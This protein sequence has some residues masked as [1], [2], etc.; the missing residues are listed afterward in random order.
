M[1]RIDR[2]RRLGAA[3]AL[4]PLFVTLSSSAQQTAAPPPPS[5]ANPAPAADDG[6]IAEIVV[7][8][9]RREEKLQEVPLAVTAL[10]AEQIQDRG[11][12]NVTDLSALAPG[13]QISK[14]ASNSTISQIT[15]RG[16]SQINPAIYWDPAVGIYVDGVYIGKAQGSVFDVVDLERV[17]VLRGPQGTLYGRNT[18]AGAINLVTRRP[19]GEFGGTASL[20]I[21]NYDAVTT[22][23]SVDL[24]KM[25]IFSVTLAARQ[26]QRSGWV[27]T[28]NDSST[29]ALNDRNGNGLRLAVDMDFAP[30]LLG[31]YRF[32]RSIVDQ[33]PNWD[34]LYR[35][36]SDLYGFYP[37][38]P[39]YASHDRLDH[40]DLNAPMFEKARIMG[41]AFTLSW[42]LDEHNQL[43]SISGY[44]TMNWDDSL[45][46]DGSPYDVAFT[47]RFTDYHQFSQDLQWL[48]NSDRINWVAGL[49]YFG[50]DGETNN[51]QHF[52]GGTPFESNYDSWY[53]TKTHAYSA[54][55]QIDYKPIDPLTLTAGVRYTSEKKELSRAFG[56]LGTPDVYLI[57]DGTNASKTFD[58]TTPMASVAWQFTPDLNAYFRYA[59]GFK[60][61]GFNGEYSNPYTTDPD[62]NVRETKTPFKPEKQRSF[63]LGTKTM[64]LDRRVVLN[65]AVYY[66]KARDLQ[67]SIF[68]GTGAAASSV[69]NAGKATIYGAELEG[70]VALWSGSRLGFNYAYLHPK[71]DEFIDAGQDVADNRAF[72]HAPKNSANVYLDLRLVRLQLG[73]LRALLDYSYTG[74]FYT[75]AYQLR[76]TDPSKQVAGDSE[77]PATSL[78]NLRVSL[79]GVKLGGTATGELALWCRNLTDEDAPTNFIDFGPGFSSLTVANFNDPRTF[80]VTGIVRW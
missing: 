1:V 12:Q 15:I 59:E 39:D 37:T 57:P 53:S 13:L 29:S 58:A 67:E 65:A 25:G 74:A 11:I 55:G 51:P 62:E 7:T 17:E 49:Y 22:K 23:A 50:D 48:G 18:L 42:D 20:E 8:A 6:K 44:R 76:P 24:P 47:Q 4:L 27:H 72:V 75:Y 32:D 60:S 69:R 10:G 43:K 73:E 3:A 46:L 36:D 34:Q 54:Y 33:T 71:Y 5:P 66:N 19:S 31:Q 16:L 64:W 45:D 52:F 2:P 9:Q 40:A 41:H 68:L 61:G 35:I 38:L 14:T 21:G 70:Q 30:G 80:G 56:I 79:G 63:E 26:E 28:S 78:L 77:V